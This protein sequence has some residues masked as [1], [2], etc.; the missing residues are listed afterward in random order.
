[1]R[2]SNR[3]LS[4]DVNLFGSCGIS[5]VNGSLP[6]VHEIGLY[7]GS[8]PL[9][10]DRKRNDHKTSYKNEITSYYRGE[11]SYCRGELYYCHVRDLIVAVCDLTVVMS[12]L[13]IT[14]Y[15]ENKTILFIYT[16][17]SN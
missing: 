7:M 12:D 15:G 8:Y 1:M 2:P 9:R 4:A 13:S 17:Q 10:I 5:K 16:L 6:F 3:M 14:K 11:R